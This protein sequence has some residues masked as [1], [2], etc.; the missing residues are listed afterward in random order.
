MMVDDFH[1]YFTLID[2]ENDFQTENYFQMMEIFSSDFSQDELDDQ[3][4]A[5]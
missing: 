3:I 5:F 4:G 1:V 2:D